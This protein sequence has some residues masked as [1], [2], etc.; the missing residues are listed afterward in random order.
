M[1]L[2]KW[3]T[4]PLI[5]LRGS[6]GIWAHCPH[7]EDRLPFLGRSKRETMRQQADD[8]SESDSTANQHDSVGLWRLLSCMPAVGLEDKLPT[9]EDEQRT[10]R[11]P[12]HL[13]ALRS[14]S[15][16]VSVDHP[17]GS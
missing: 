8:N 3:V 15:D 5:M 14:S 6:A 17:G 12:A 1:R 2:C 9:E 7:G 4:P 11:I 10:D 16:R 13:P